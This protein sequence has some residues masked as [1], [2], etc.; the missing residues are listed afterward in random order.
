MPGGRSQNGN[1]GTDL[2]AIEEATVRH[3]CCKQMPFGRVYL[4]TFHFCVAQ[5]RVVEP[6]D[7]QL[8]RLSIPKAQPVFH[9]SVDLMFENTE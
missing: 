1:Q 6:L 5:Q 2:N 3:V 8:E 7:Q 9:E 4:P